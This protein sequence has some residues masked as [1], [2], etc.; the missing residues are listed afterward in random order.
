VPGSDDAGAESADVTAS[1]AAPSDVGSRMVS[2]RVSPEADK[3]LV[4]SAVSMFSVMF[5]LA[6]SGDVVDEVLLTGVSLHEVRVV[7]ERGL[8]CC[9][10]VRESG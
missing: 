10:R 1:V 2:G 9:D 5:L 4:V 3:G 8:G 7:P 6:S